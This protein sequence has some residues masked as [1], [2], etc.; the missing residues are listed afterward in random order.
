MPAKNLDDYAAKEAVRIARAVDRRGFLQRAAVTTSAG[1]ASALGVA[2]KA[3]AHHN[4][5][6][7][8]GC[9]STYNPSGCPNSFGCGLA[10][11]VIQTTV[12]VPIAPTGTARSPPAMATTVGPGPFV[13]AISLVGAAESRAPGGPAAIAP[14]G[15]HVATTAVAAKTLGFLVRGRQESAGLCANVLS[16]N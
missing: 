3:E 12:T 10:P 4:Y 15:T 9:P 2:T 8:A 11:N 5:T 1:L 14:V 13:V 16:E 6:V 7:R